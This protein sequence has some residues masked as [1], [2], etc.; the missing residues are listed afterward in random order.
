MLDDDIL[1]AALTPP[2][3]VTDHSAWVSHIPFAF[4]LIE[5]LRPRNFVELGTHNGDSY[6]AFCQAVEQQQKSGACRDT[7][8]TAIDTWQGD[9][10]AGFYDETVLAELRRHHDPLYASFSKLHR[11]T[12]AQAAAQFSSGQIDLLHIDGSHSY[13]EVRADFDR[14]LPL[15]SSR[16]VVLLH[17]TQVI[18]EGFGVAKLWQEISAARPHFEFLHGYGLGVLQIG[19]EPSP[20]MQKFFQFAGANPTLLR[21]LFASLGQRIEFS[22]TINRVSAQLAAQIE[23][24]SAWRAGIG[25]APIQPPPSTDKLAWYASLVTGDLNFLTKKDRPR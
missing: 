25:A 5:M 13:D 18:S 6:C 16:G 17:D 3:R 20:G 15:I 8:C 11:A 24:L 7:R 2:R 23:T 4:A 14:W 22:R 21:D 1:Q 19:P 12:F 10:S 9:L